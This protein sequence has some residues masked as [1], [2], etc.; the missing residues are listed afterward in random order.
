MTLFF[1]GAICKIMKS[2]NT[3]SLHGHTLFIDQC[4]RN[5]ASLA[6][7]WISLLTKSVSSGVKHS[8]VN[9]F[10]FVLSFVFK[11]HF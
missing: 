3:P 2:V 9:Y 7:N 6:L 10:C 1:K 11:C 4:K 8:S 5:I